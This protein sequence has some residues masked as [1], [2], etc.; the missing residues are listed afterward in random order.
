MEEPL[1]PVAG[2]PQPYGTAVPAP[3]RRRV[4]I[5]FVVGG[6][7][8]LAFLVVASLLMYTAARALGGEDDGFSSLGDDNIGVIDIDGEILS[9]DTIVDQLRK[10]DQDSSIK[11][12]ILHIDSPGGA[13]A[14]SQEIYHEVLR[15]RDEKKKPV[16]ASIESVGASGAYYIAS[17]AS[18]IYAND[19][20]VVGSIGVIMEWTNYGDLLTWAKLKPEVIHAGT[21]KDAGDPSHAMTPEERV[22]FQGLV[23][24]MYGQFIADVANGRHLPAGDIKTLATGQVWTGE[25]AV[26]LHLIDKEGGFR[27]ALLETAKSVGISGE[28]SVVK[29]IFH[30]RTIWDLISNTDDLIHEPIK[31]VEQHAGFYFLWR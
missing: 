3:R 7:L 10:Y 31:L 16:V 23:D 21:L 17:A 13:A 29:P 15:I 20:S 25:Q 9:A 8:V 11:A 2:V 30:H 12:I 4:W 27:V 18:K 19:A 5:W 1:T 26:P 24:D 6:G 28:P 14:P 22:Y